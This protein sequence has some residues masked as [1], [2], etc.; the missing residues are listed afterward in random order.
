[1]YDPSIAEYMQTLIEGGLTYIDNISTQDS[2][3][4]TTHHHGEDDHMEFL[5]RP[6]NQALESLRDRMHRAK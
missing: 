1:M 4:N 3:G 6:F 5:K 2:P